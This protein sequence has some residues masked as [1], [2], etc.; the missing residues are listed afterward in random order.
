MDYTNGQSEWF[1]NKH[2]FYRKH[3]PHQGWSGGYHAINTVTNLMHN[4]RKNVLPFLLCCG[5]IVLFVDKVERGCFAGRLQLS[6]LAII[7]KWRASFLTNPI[8]Y[9]CK[10]P[11]LDL[12]P[13]K[14]SMF[15]GCH[16]NLFY[17][18]L[19]ASVHSG[20]KPVSWTNA[21]LSLPYELSK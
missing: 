5:N 3:N 9:L 4:T 1:N 14:M 11:C 2:L 12:E 10:P 6:W 7:Q 15:T 8:Y 21:N 19:D 16:E 13:W 18:A 17:V 20:K